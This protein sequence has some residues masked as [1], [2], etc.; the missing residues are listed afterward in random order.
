MFGTIIT[1]AIIFY[2]LMVIA[3]WKILEKAGEPGWKALIPIYNVYML[4][5]IVGMKNWF[6]T[7]IIVSIVSSLIMTT[8]G[9]N[10]NM[11]TANQIA[12]IEPAKMTFVYIIAIAELVFYI[13]MA[14][15]YSIRTSRAFGHG[16]GFAVG[17][18][19]LSSIFWLIL[20]F[21]RSKYNKKVALKK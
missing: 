16:T 12:A 9:Y 2:I 14:V 5:K 7:T 19:F 6:W 13:V 21:G 10:P 4:Y 3:S 18:F 20:G 17:L 1:F 11:M 8:L 15:I